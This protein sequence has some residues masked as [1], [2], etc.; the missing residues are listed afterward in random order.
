MTPRPWRPAFAALVM[1]MTALSG[2]SSS[3]ASA[4]SVGSGQALPGTSWLAEDIGRRG[5][6]DNPQPTMSFDQAGRV[7]GSGGCNRYGGPVEISG[8]AIRFGP[9]ASTRMACAP[10]IGDQEER[11]FAALQSAT[12]F[13][14]TPEDKLVLYDA[15]GTAVVTF[16]RME[17]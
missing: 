8:E 7:S 15:T 17:P 3:G 14:F 13:A 9:L 12:R 6:L 11:F 2:C 1:M 4:Q 10:A 5:V 16:S